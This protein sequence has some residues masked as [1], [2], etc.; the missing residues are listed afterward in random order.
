M[1]GAINLG[2]N[3]IQNRDVPTADSN[4][5]TKQYVHSE[6]AGFQQQGDSKYV[7]KTESTFMYLNVGSN[8]AYSFA[9]SG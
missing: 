3:K 5:A 2:G 8:V 6:V 1:S 4:A 7:Q 9:K